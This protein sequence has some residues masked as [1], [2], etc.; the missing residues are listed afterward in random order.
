MFLYVFVRVGCT[1]YDIF[2]SEYAPRFG[3]R[4]VVLAEM[5]AVS[6][7]FFYQFHV[8]VDDEYG[9]IIVAEFSHFRGYGQY[10]VFRRIFHAQLYPA[11]TAFQSHAGGV[12]VRIPFGIMCNEL[13]LFHSLSAAGSFYYYDGYSFGQSIIR[14]FRTWNH[15]VIGSN[16]YALRR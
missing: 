2:L 9:A 8:V 15:T 1:A 3:N 4:H 5:Y 10:F 14:P 12:E 11:A 7:D 13:N 6:P 16:G